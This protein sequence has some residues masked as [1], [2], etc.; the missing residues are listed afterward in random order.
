MYILYL[1][2]KIHPYINALEPKNVCSLWKEAG[3][4]LKN[5][6]GC[7]RK[8]NLLGVNIND[9]LKWNA[10]VKYLI[11]KSSNDSFPFVN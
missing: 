9:D 3:D 5:H 10:R 7:K 8:K 2:N 6:G 1:S 11:G 4:R